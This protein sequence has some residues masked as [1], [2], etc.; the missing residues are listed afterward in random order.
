MPLLPHV[1][2]SLGVARS[3][4]QGPPGV[5]RLA[6]EQ[7]LAWAVSWSLPCPGAWGQEE[8]LATRCAE[9]QRPL[10]REAWLPQPSSGDAVWDPGTLQSCSCEATAGPRATAPARWLALRSPQGGTSPATPGRRP[11]IQADQVGWACGAGTP[12]WLG[13]R[14]RGGATPPGPQKQSLRRPWRSR[15]W[16]AGRSHPQAS[17]CAGP[18]GGLQPARTSW[19]PH[20]AARL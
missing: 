12:G 1:W 19:L 15:L 7:I 4:S 5:G 18:R 13:G 20:A 2:A 3:S 8:G 9:G 10:G 17:G 14:I 6:G 11:S 16:D